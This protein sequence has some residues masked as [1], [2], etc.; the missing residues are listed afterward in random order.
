M[1]LP[2]NSML[3][4]GAIRGAAAATPG[5]ESASSSA[6]PSGIPGSFELART[7]TVTISVPS[8]SN[9]RRDSE[10]AISPVEIIAITEA[11]PIMMPMRPRTVRRRARVRLRTASRRLSLTARPHRRVAR[12]RPPAWRRLRATPPPRIRTRRVHCVEIAESCVM[13]TIAIP[14]SRFSWLSRRMTS[15]AVSASSAPVGSSAS[16]T[17]GSPTRARAIA[18]RCF[19]PP[20]SWSGLWSRRSPMP[21]FP[22]IARAR[23]RTS[24]RPMRR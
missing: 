23:R 22:R 11:M 5:T 2:A 6:W 24:R 13:M 17:A 10:V 14:F 8:A 21:T 18:T 15:S 7:F 19:C 20:E 12:A 16:T 1:R 9:C 4:P 3:P